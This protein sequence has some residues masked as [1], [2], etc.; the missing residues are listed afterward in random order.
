MVDL[1]LAMKKKSKN[2]GQAQC[3]DKSSGNIEGQ[4]ELLPIVSLDGQIGSG[5]QIFPQSRVSIDLRHER[6]V[7]REPKKW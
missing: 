2:Q 6:G 3:G 5:S 1:Y 4:H 7:C